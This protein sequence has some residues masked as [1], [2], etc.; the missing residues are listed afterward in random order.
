VAKPYNRI[1]TT[2]TK[3]RQGAIYNAFSPIH[4]AILSLLETNK[5]KDKIKDKSTLSKT[6]RKHKSTKLDTETDN[7]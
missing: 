5:I 1:A 3:G 6:N 4:E 2:I 7:K